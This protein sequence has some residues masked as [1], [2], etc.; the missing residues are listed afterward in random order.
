MKRRHFIAAAT[1]SLLSALPASA[2]NK[3]KTSKPGQRSAGKP[4]AKTPA[5]KTTTPREDNLNSLN[6]HGAEA[7]HWQYFEVRFT[8]DAEPFAGGAKVW[9]PLPGD[10]DTPWQRSLGH[11]WEGNF[12]HAHLYRDPASRIEAF[13][14]QWPAGSDKPHLQIVSQIATQDRRFDITRRANRIESAET[15][16]NALRTERNVTTESSVQMSAERIIGRIKDPLAQAKALYEWIV[17]Q[18]NFA[19]EGAGIGTGR[20]NESLEAKTLTGKSADISLLFVDLC[21]SIGIP[22]RPVFGLRIAKSRFFNCPVAM[23]ELGKEQHCRAEFYT[24]AYGWIPVDPASVIEAAYLE[25]LRQDNPKWNNLKK[26]FF[27]FWEMNWISFNSAEVPRLAGM[28]DNPSPF[29]IHPEIETAE[30]RLKDQD[31]NRLRYRI[32]ARQVTA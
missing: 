7:E 26:L 4:A 15:L 19:P 6:L 18:V 23:E 9:L 21:R 1:L 24:A 12:S 28:T 30:G 14:A 2:A 20:L 22:A 29:F 17:E 13:N 5:K 31:R 3:K 27:G 16:R 25:Q 8:L 11:R 10:R 32:E